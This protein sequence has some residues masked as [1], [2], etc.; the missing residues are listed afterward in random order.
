MQQAPLN[1]QGQ[2][3]TRGP[4][5]SAERLR[6][7]IRELRGRANRRLAEAE[8]RRVLGEAKTA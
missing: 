8:L 3:P 2:M 4:V 5:E 7:K 6:V 1:V